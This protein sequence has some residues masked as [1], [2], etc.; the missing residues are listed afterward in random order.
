MNWKQHLLTDL[1]R[2]QPSCRA[3]IK[4]DMRSKGH[5]LILPLEG[6]RRCCVTKKEVPGLGSKTEDR[7]SWG[8]AKP[9]ARPGG[10]S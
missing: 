5:N 6:S 2:H 1:L 7:W 3:E 8:V 4:T 9:S 10:G